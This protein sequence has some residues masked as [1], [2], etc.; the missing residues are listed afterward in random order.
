MNKSIMDEK[1]Y[2]ITKEIMNFLDGENLRIETVME[3]GKICKIIITKNKDEKNKISTYYND[4]KE[5]NK[6][7]KEDIVLKEITYILHKIGIPAHI[8]GYHYLREAI[9][10]AYKNEKA[11]NNITGIMYPKIAKKYKAT[12]SS[13]ERAIRHAIEGVCTNRGNL[14]IINQIFGYTIKSD[15]GKPTNSEFIAMIVE[16][17]KIKHRKFT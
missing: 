14:N 16:K 4:S 10:I 3:Y 17:I 2:E 15:K 11:I 1:K 13:V 8:K 5:I 12:P 6:E 9:F 7:K